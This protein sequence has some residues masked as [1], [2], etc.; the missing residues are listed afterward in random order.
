MITCLVREEKYQY[1]VYHIVKAFFPNET[2]EQII[3][4]KGTSFFIEIKENENTLLFIEE[5]ELESKYTK[6]S[7]NKLLYDKLSTLTGQALDWGYLM[8]VRPSKIAMKR[9]LEGKNKSEV[10]QYLIKEYRVN[11]QKAQL[12]TDIAIREAALLEN[13]DCEDGYSLYVG[14]PFC[15]TRCSYCSFTAYPFKKW[16]YRIE[17]YLDALLKEID[18]VAKRSATKKL[19]TVYIGGG[20]PTTLTA[21][22][23]ERLI[24]NIKEKFSFDSVLEFTVEAGRPDTITVE[25]LEVMKRHGVDRISINPQTMQDETLK[26]IGRNHTAAD[27]KAVFDQARALGFD[28]INMDIIVGLESE[29]VADVEATLSAIKEM[30]PD[31]LTVHSLAMKRGSIAKERGAVGRYGKEIEKMIEYS[32]AYAKNMELLPYYLYRQKN[33]A[34]NYE[35]VGYAKVDKAGIYN[36]LIMEEK[37]SIIAVGAGATTKIVRPKEKE[38]IIRIENVKDIDAYIERIDEML[39]RKGDWLWR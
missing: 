28:N 9:L 10:I 14:I 31:N 23:L 38:K 27:I 33:I 26:K 12:V 11:P 16:E 13:I 34:G 20:T 18:F 19:N 32:F 8:G 2:I 36:I 39:E 15:M 35:N 25:K 1:D 3:I 24:V 4:D 5:E 22:Q 6:R 17:E 37:Q 7:V 21:E 29:S 30:K